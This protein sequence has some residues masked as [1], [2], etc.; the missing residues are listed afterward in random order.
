MDSYSFE[1]VYGLK[2][3]PAIARKVN[4]AK[5]A[6]IW[7]LIGTVILKNGQARLTETVQISLLHTVQPSNTTWDTSNLS[8]LGDFFNHLTTSLLPLVIY[9]AIQKAYCIHFISEKY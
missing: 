6:T 3:D 7:S 1:N 5:K 8:L 4:V 9:F 2:I